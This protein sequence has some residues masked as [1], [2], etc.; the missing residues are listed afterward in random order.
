MKEMDEMHLHQS[1]IQPYDH[2]DQ[3]VKLE[4][5]QKVEHYLN[6]IGAPAALAHDEAG[7]LEAREELRSHIES[8]IEANIELGDTHELAVAHAL[9][10]FGRSRT[11]RREFER[12]NPASMKRSLLTA[13]GFNAAACVIAVTII[14]LGIQYVGDRGWQAASEVTDLGLYALPAAAGLLTGLFAKR[15]PILATLYSLLALMLPMATLDA[16]QS[17]GIGDSMWQIGVISQFVIFLMCWIPFGC[18]G[19]GV[20]SL[21]RW[22][23]QRTGRRAIA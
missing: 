8:L 10:Q 11:I 15:R 22:V 2:L 21:M 16:I 5:N 9:E 18:A 7:I 12:N 6:Q 23:M 14:P 4:S 20:G 13:I 3:Q 19:A 17:R 1:E